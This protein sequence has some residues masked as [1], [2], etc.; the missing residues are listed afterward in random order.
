MIFIGLFTFIAFTF[1]TLSFYDNYNLQ[2]IENYINK[3]KCEEY[4]Y[5]KGSYKA[6]CEDRLLEI[7]NSFSVNIKNDRKE[8]IYVEINSLDVD[9]KS[10]IINDT[11]EIFFSKEEELNAFYKKL[12]KKLNK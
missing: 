12:E 6:L 2:K 10:I 9:K 8:F 5:T 11:E 4:I 1:I 3:N 7:P